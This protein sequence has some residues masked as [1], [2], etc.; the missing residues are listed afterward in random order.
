MVINGVVSVV[1]AVTPVVVM[2]VVVMGVAPV[3]S[4]V[5]VI[6][7]RPMDVILVPLKVLLAVVAF[8]LNYEK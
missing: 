7:V 2:V 4:M 5:V 6:V 1:I 8:F 3:R